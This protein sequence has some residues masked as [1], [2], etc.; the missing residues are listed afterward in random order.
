MEWV[1]IAILQG[2]GKHQVSSFSGLVWLIHISPSRNTQRRG[3]S[4]WKWFCFEYFFFFFFYIYSA[5]VKIDHVGDKAA[6]KNTMSL[7]WHANESKSGTSHLAS[8]Q[9]VFLHLFRCELPLPL[10]CD[11]GAACP[12]QRLPLFAYRDLGAP[13][14]IGPSLLS[15]VTM[16]TVFAVVGT[17]AAG[18]RTSPRAHVLFVHY[19]P[20]ISIPLWE[21]LASLGPLDDPRGGGFWQGGLSLR[22]GTV[23][24]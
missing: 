10:L 11:H 2:R 24:F 15:Q 13:A 17:I 16:A 19:L 4:S 6:F 3:V 20:F 23:W 18:R 22:F 12:L 5:R 9:P 7:P 1:I 21:W 8:E 14:V